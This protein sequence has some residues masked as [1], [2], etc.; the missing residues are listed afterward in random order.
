MKVLK[1]SIDPKAWNLALTCHW[2]KSQIEI[3]A[4]DLSYEGEP[5][6]M[7]DAGWDKYSCDCGACGEEIEVD[8]KK[9]PNIIQSYAEKRKKKR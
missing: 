7:K 8:E 4:D 6:D 3:N 1:Y 5:G 9:I 2:C